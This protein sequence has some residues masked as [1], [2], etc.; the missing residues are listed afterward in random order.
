MLRP[1]HGIAGG[2][3]RGGGMGRSGGEEG[4]VEGWGEVAVQLFWWSKFAV[5]GCIEQ[6]LPRTLPHQAQ[7][8]FQ[9][10]HL[11][12]SVTRELHQP[13]DQY[14]ERNGESKIA[15]RHIYAAVERCWHFLIPGDDV[16]W[17]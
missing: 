12:V 13:R 9:I 6:V 10:S 4:E 11:C 5:H 16:N 8:I 3:G 7:I 2:G 14:T 1:G 15:K 17:R